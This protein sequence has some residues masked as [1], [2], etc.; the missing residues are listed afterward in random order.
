MSSN[1]YTLRPTDLGTPKDD[2]QFSFNGRDVGRPYGR[3]A[4]RP[5]LV[6]GRIIIVLGYAGNG[7]AVSVA[8]RR[9]AVLAAARRKLRLTGPRSRENCEDGH[10]EHVHPGE[11]AEP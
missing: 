11:G 3:H 8:V 7:A 10:H 4:K 9:A 6:I 5:T 1:K 2:F